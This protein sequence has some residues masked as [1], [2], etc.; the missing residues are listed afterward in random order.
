MVYSAEAGGKWLTTKAFREQFE[1]SLLSWTEEAGVEGAR[2]WI[3]KGI[4]GVRSGGKRRVEAFGVFEVYIHLAEAMVPGRVDGWLSIEEP[5][6][7]VSEHVRKKHVSADAYFEMPLRV[8]KTSS[9]DESVFGCGLYAEEE[10]RGSDGLMRLASLKA[11]LD[12]VM[13]D[14]IDVETKVEDDKGTCG[15][16]DGA[17]STS[18]SASGRRRGRRKRTKR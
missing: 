15:A 7:Q 14:N 2:G 4:N 16:N 10:R 1:R 18:R 6:W 12:T 9:A 5:G 11:E 13:F 8:W 17:G 3:G